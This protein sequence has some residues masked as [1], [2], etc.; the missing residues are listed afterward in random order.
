MRDDA[1]DELYQSRGYPPM[2]HPSSDPAVTSVAARFAG[3]KPPHPSAARILE[4]GC[5]AGHNLLPLAARWPGASFTGVD[6]SR[7]MVAEAE[8]RARGAGITNV[9]FAAADLRELDFAGREFDYIIAHGVFSWVEDDAKKALLDFCAAHLGPSGI[10]TISFNLWTGWER[11]LPVIDAVRRI[12]REHGVDVIKG[13]AILREVIDD[14]GVRATVDDMLAKGAEILAF[15]D[16]APVNDP[17]PLDRFAAAAVACGL[18]WLGDSD[19]AENIPSSLDDAARESLAPL[20]GDPLLMQMTADAMADRTFRSALL[21]R[22]D[23]PLAQKMTTGMVM[24]LGVRP[25]E[26]PPASSFG[27][28][29]DFLAALE[30]FRPDCVAVAEVLG[31][32]KEPDVPIFAR[33]VF[34]AITRGDLRA[35]VEPVVIRKEPLRPRLDP[36]RLLCAKESV[37]LVDAWHSPCVFS[38]RTYPL[39]AE[40]DGTRSVEELAGIS[41]E[42]CPDLAFPIWLRHLAERGLFD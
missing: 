41:K 34:Q 16:F 15:D 24:D 40:M 25:P 13:L 21:C 1:V 42:R 29:A 6:I 22:A 36:F 10:A 30:S 38:E 39:L 19:P 35:R 28:L 8:R 32:L 18:R 14:A 17:W 31:R 3:L 37:P 7:P 12:Q 20:V 26:D 4:I 2:S 9:S 11:R 23:A 27:P 33:V 5:A